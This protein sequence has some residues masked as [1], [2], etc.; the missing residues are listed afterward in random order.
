M[1]IFEDLKP[2]LQHGDL[3]ILTAASLHMQGLGYTTHV[4]PFDELPADLRLEWMQPD[5]GGYLLHIDRDR[6]DEGM[7]ALGT[8]FGYPG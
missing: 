7:N 4:G 8:Y 6:W 5:V 1:S 2:V 3:E